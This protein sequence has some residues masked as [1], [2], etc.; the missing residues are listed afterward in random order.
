MFQLEPSRL[1]IN[2][3]N[4]LPQRGNAQLCNRTTPVPTSGYR[5]VLPVQRDLAS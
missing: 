4:V 1:G 5:A 3:V 2:I